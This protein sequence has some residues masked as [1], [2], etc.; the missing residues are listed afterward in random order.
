MNTLILL[1]ETERSWSPVVWAVERGAE[2]TEDGR[3][4]L[5]ER[6]GWLSIRPDQSLLDDFGDDE[7]ADALGGI[8]DP[9]LFVVE[10]RGDWLIETFVDAVPPECRAFVDNDHGVFVPVTLLQ[11]VPRAAW[12]RVAA[13]Q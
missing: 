12:A 9:S 3:T 7:K 5:D 6:D 13:L 1:A 2:S 4:I 8:A 10:W 11:N